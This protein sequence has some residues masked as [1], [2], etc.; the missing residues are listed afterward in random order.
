M[1]L[2]AMVV[3]VSVTVGLAAGAGVDTLGHG[4]VTVGTLLGYWFTGV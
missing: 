1:I 2:G 3:G 4:L